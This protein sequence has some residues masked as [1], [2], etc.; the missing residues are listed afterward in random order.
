MAPTVLSKTSTPKIF[1]VIVLIIIILIIILI[2]FI[3]KFNPINENSET[4]A[5]ETDFFITICFVIVILLLCFSLLPNFEDLRQLFSQINSVVYVV[6]YTIFLTIF[7]NV[8]SKSIINTYAIIVLLT[9]ILPGIY[10]FYNG[11][12]PNYIAEFNVNYE[13]L[14]TMIIFFCL[15][16][17]LFVY[18]ISNPGGYITKYMGPSFIFT[19]ILVIFSFLYLLIILTLTDRSAVPAPG[20]KVSSALS[21]FSK[22]SSYGVIT[23]FIFI[24][25]MVIIFLLNPN[26]FFNNVQNIY[27]TIVI[28]LIIVVLW[29][30]LIG[31]TLFPELHDST[32]EIDKLNLFKR[33]LLVLFG[34]V[35]IILLIIL[36]CYNITNYS[37]TTLISIILNGLIVLIVLGLIYKTIK[38]KLP[39]GDHKKNTLVS[40]ISNFVYYLPCIFTDGFDILMNKIFIPFSQF[41]KHQY[42][43]TPYKYIV[44][45]FLSIAAILIYYF[46]PSIINILLLQG[47]IQ[48]VN[49]P[50]YTN[51]LYLL[52]NSEQLNETDLPYEYA[53]SFWV[54][55]DAAPPSTN[56]SYSTFAS[57]LNFGG[58]PNVTYNA[59]LNTFR[60][61][62]EIKDLDKVTKNPFIEF[63][64]NGSKIVYTNK[65]MLL[66]K[67]NNII[68]NYNKGILDIFL[69]G[70]LVK[71][72]IGVPYYKI[73]T[74]SIG[75]PSGI[76]GG[77]CNVIYF[78]RA[79][80]TIHINYLYNLSKKRTPPLLNESNKTI[81][82]EDLNLVKTST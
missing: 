14:K 23:F 36:I 65:N 16:A 51:T 25:S 57:L 19:L 40:L 3:Y 35:M 11:M 76:N 33:S 72:D 50:V 29:T 69:N 66:Q 55:I 28:S 45:L 9:T 52:G 68:L 59:K 22:T 10:I 6:F 78:K 18:Y 46:T 34:L 21:G 67:W 41:F 13:R 12:K 49:Q 30:I 82:N 26:K 80:N 17:L 53:L 60:I 47:G 20:A 42:E 8:M 27:C 75:E 1:Y 31:S 43:I 39:I 54:F 74:L 56:Q 58:K 32:I 64:K 81:T 73:E 38:V 44:I 4:I 70:E 5:I 7:F 37:Q 15:I 61:T 62:T 2:C 24:I 79:L 48:L 63:D 77:I 71:T